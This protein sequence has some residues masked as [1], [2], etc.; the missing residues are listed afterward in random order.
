MFAKAG[1]PDL[2]EFKGD[3]AVKT[4]SAYFPAFRLLGH[5]KHFPSGII[6]EGGGY[7]CFLDRIKLGIFRIE[8]SGSMLGDGLEVMKIIY[9]APVNP[10]FLKLLTDEVREVRP[11]YYICRGIYNIFGKPTNIMYFT[12]EQ[13]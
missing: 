9:D 6:K 1:V 11:G 8:I 4:V 3:Y 13:L 5:R 7:N 2:D 12:L 10:F